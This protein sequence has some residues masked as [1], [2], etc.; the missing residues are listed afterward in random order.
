V[1]LLSSGTGWLP[2]LMVLQMAKPLVRLWAAAGARLAVEPS[3]SPA[4]AAAA[5][6]GSLQRTRRSLLSSATWRQQQHMHARVGALVQRW[7]ALRRWCTHNE[8]HNS[9]TTRPTAA[10]PTAAVVACCCGHPLPAPSPC[11]GQSLRAWRPVRRPAPPPASRWRLSRRGAARPQGGAGAGAPARTRGP[12]PSPA[13]APG[14]TPDAQ[15]WSSGAAAFAAGCRPACVWLCAAHSEVS[16]AAGCV[17]MAR[18]A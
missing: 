7:P 3:H 4:V 15:G 12:A 10:R 13:P 18:K 1:V 8:M 11:A 17:R 5:A 9:A 14:C 6:V 16:V 2:S